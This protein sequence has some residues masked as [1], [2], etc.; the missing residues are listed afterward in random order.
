MKT[1]IY[2]L[3]TVFVL[4]LIL[5]IKIRV[6]MKYKDFLKDELYKKTNRIVL[7]LDIL[8]VIC[9]IIFLVINYLSLESFDF[10]SVLGIIIDSLAISLLICPISLGT[11]YRSSYKS[12]KYCLIKSVVTSYVPSLK[13]AKAFN[14]AGINLIVETDEEVSLKYP[15][16]CKVGKKDLRKNM[17]I[18]SSL[19][20]DVLKIK[21]EYTVIED[22]DLNILY[23]KIRESRGIDDNY[24]RT[25]KY[26]II[27]YLPLVGSYLLFL[28]LD[29]PI[30]YNIL[31]TLIIKLFTLIMSELVYKYLDYDTDI[32]ERKPKNK[33]EMM[34]KEDFILSIFISFIIIFIICIPYMFIL[35]SNGSLKQVNTMLYVIMIYTNIFISISYL[36]EKMFLKNIIKFFKNWKMIIYG[37]ILIMVSIVINFINSS[38]TMNI[39]IQNYIACVI[40]SLFP[41]LLM[42][43]IKL[44]RYQSGKKRRGVKYAKNNK[45]YRR[46]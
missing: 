17:V 45:K 27:T 38:Y 46:S 35:S 26:I 8:S 23:D 11:L 4:L 37:V 21:D 7:L 20:D 3:L 18:S 16:V 2:I 15:R 6:M 40:I 1:I 33:K 12:R 29:F 32:M 24:N 43:F 34:G 19:L 30:A 28:F 25:W 36:S 39:G 41:L 10:I 42:E 14:R 44:A 5:G 9:F 22:N 31:V 13:L